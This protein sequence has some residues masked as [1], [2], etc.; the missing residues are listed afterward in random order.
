MELTENCQGSRRPSPKMAS[1]AYAEGNDRQSLKCSSRK[2]PATVTSFYRPLSS[3]ETIKAGKGR[4]WTDPLRMLS[5]PR[6][7]VFQMNLS[8]MHV[9]PITVMSLSSLGRSKVHLS[10]AT[11]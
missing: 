3:G 4:A 11:L 1:G 8:E 5:E 7:N 10:K 6:V 9:K 2:R